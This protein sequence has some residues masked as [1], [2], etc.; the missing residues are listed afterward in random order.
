MTLAADTSPPTPAQL[1]EIERAHATIARL[2]RQLERLRRQND[3]LLEA[4]RIERHRAWGARSEKSP[5]QAELFDEAEDTPLESEDDEVVLEE[6]PAAPTPRPRRPPARRPLPPSL[7]RRRLVHELPESERRCP[8]GC[9]MVEIGEKRSE[10]LEIIP[11]KVEVIEHVRKSYACKGCEERATVRTAAAPASM[12]PKSIASDN[13]LA[14]LIVA[15]YADGLPLY[16]LSTILARHGIELPRQTLSESVLRGAAR[17]EPLIAALGE[18]LR[19]GAVLHMDETRVQVLNEPGKAARSQSYMWV[20]R[21]GP[22][23]EVVVHFSYEPSRAAAVP[24]RLLGDYAGAV[25]TDGYEAY[26]RVARTG[27]FTHLACWAHARRKFVEAK[28]GQVKGASGRA[29][30]AIALI[31]KLYGVERAQANS[32]VEA[33]ERARQER[34]VAVL[35]QLREWLEES[36]LKVPPK[37]ALGKAVHYALEYWP[38]LARYVENGAWPIDNNVAE[39]AIRPFVIGRKAWMFSD[40]QR[41]ARASANLYSLIETAKANGREP[42]RYLC[43]LFERLPTTPAEEILTLAPWNAPP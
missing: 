29:D 30:V 9:T 36:A 2:E 37:G 19:E 21:G 16:R 32:D 38:E 34:S 15:K 42:Y 22:P 18:H 7:P 17:L 41:G 6:E 27:A 26:R 13:T 20:Q 8:C 5:E 4:L 23:G 24:E 31:G 28:K 39:N 12:L 11:A 10:E 1:A 40:S 25:M 14:Y 3:T 33:R 43:W 35:G